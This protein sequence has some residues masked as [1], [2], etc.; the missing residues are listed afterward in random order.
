MVSLA[1]PWR[2]FTIPPLTDAVITMS[3][4][5]Y[6]VRADNGTSQ[7]RTISTCAVLKT[8]FGPNFVCR[9]NLP[10]MDVQIN[11]FDN[12]VIFDANF[13]SFNIVGTAIFFVL[14]FSYVAKV[15]IYVC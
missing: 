15:Y 4:R 2:R 13:R 11:C 12:P 9:S 10:I 6:K 5:N 8:V 7:M 3:N 14:F 1:R